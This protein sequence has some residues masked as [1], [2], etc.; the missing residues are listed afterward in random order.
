MPNNKEKLIIKLSKIAF[1]FFTRI[2]DFFKFKRA[3]FAILGDKLGSNS[4]FLYSFLL[5]NNKN[6]IIITGSKFQ[7]DALKKRN[8]EAHYIFSFT[9]ILRLGISKWI[10]VEDALCDD[11]LKFKSTHQKSLQL[12][13][14]NDKAL[15]SS[16]NKIKYDAINSSSKFSLSIKEKYLTSD[17]FIAL[18]S[19]KNDVLL[20]EKLTQNDIIFVDKKIYEFIRNLR[21]SGKKILVLMPKFEQNEI[22]DLFKF[23]EFLIKKNFFLIIK[24]DNKNS[25][26]YEEMMKNKDLSNILFA[27]FHSEATPF[28]RFCDILISN[29]FSVI[30]NFLLLNKAIIHL[31]FNE[32]ESIFPAC[33]NFYEKANSLEELQDLICKIFCSQDDFFD[34][35][36]KVRANVFDYFDD[37]NSQRLSEFMEKN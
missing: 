18:G 25:L 9:G 35:R 12:W 26:F 21:A 11:I 10:V 37:K 19:P 24:F 33:Q 22:F 36:V 30:Y 6:P 20:K 32:G 13:A 16:L 27:Q 5:E 29:D 4:I 34:A 7:L 28:L 31:G 3:R 14:Q 2:L 17:N 8:L 15:I 23:N 1:Y